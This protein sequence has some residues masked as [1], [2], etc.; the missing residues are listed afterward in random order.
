M[1]IDSGDVM[2][3]RL[4]TNGT[5]EKGLTIK[6]VTPKLDKKYPLTINPIDKN[7]E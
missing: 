6:F 5:V 1:V 3:W 4:D 2:D 7:Q